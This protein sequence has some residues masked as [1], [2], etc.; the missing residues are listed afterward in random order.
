MYTNRIW[1]KLSKTTDF[2]LHFT[3]KICGSRRK[4][5]ANEL[6]I[7]HESFLRMDHFISLEILQPISKMLISSVCF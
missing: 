1:G 5:K 4:I 7:C 2:L 3:I 6:K